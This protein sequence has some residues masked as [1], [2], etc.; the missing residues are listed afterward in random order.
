MSTERAIAGPVRVFPDRAYLAELIRPWK[1][2][3]LAL[4]MAWLLFGGLNYSISDW[5]V[6]ISVLMGCLTYVCA[7]WSVATILAAVR[8]RSRV[9]LYPSVMA[10]AAAWFVVD[11]AYVCYH[12]LLGN[13]MLRVENFFV[14]SALYFLA[15]SIWL[16]PGT[17]HEFVRNLRDLFRGPPSP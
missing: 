3:S 1:L 5:D 4:G 16:Y 10:L 2:L 15:G 13:Q 12:T 8:Y 14:S 17:L 7:P 6:G 11:G 9:W